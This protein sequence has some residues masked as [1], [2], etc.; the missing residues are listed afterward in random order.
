MAV[1]KIAVA[2][3]PGSG[4]AVV[5]VGTSVVVGAGEDVGV[6]VAAPVDG[7]FL[8]LESFKIALQRSCWLAGRVHVTT[9]ALP[10]PAY[11]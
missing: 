2:R 7:Q 5:G 11:E 1:H 4:T 8:V 6:V 9:E 10:S 3:P